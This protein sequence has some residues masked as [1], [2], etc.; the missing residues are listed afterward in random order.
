METKRKEDAMK[1]K[2]FGEL[3]AQM[4]HEMKVSCSF[5]YVQCSSFII[6]LLLLSCAKS[7]MPWPVRK[8]FSS[9]H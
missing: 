3:K 6:M 4:E 9:D 5:V 8:R 1:R 2:Q 7:H